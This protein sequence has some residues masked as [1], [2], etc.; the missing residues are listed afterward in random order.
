LGCLARTAAL[1][2]QRHHPTLV[3]DRVVEL[4]GLAGLLHDVGHF[5]FSHVG[6]AA[7]SD[8]AT[9]L[10]HHEKRSEAIVEWMVTKYDIDLAPR[11]IDV[12]RRMINP[13]AKDKE[14]W[15]FQIVSG[16]IDVD[17]CDYVVRDSQ[18]VGVMTGFGL[19]HVHHIIDHCRIVDGKLAF[20]PK[21]A[22]DCHDL[23]VARRDLHHKVYQHRVS[24]AIEAMIT[25]VLHLVEP[26]HALKASVHS[27]PRFTAL[28]DGVLMQLYYDPTT[29]LPARALIQRIWDRSLYTTVQEFDSPH[30]LRI[31]EPPPEGVRVHARWIGMDTGEN[32]P[33]DC[34]AFTDRLKRFWGEEA[35]RTYRVSVIATT[36]D[37]RDA[38]LVWCEA[39]VPNLG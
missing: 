32:H 38:A 28:N 10:R 1:A 39:L 33:M 7:L 31:T 35:H 17:R 13:R 22:R 37:R 5:A 27:I 14:D 20:Q 15:R 16:T 23:L 18:N 24:L 29:P 21:V 25:D 9:P 34:I 6:D 11:E 3:S 36:K 30:A 4:L 26:T 8:M 19:H 12:V 2:L